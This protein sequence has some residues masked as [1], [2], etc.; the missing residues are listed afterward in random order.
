MAH[1]GQYYCS[2]PKHVTRFHY[3][4]R[5]SVDWSYL[6]QIFRQF[7]HQPTNQLSKQP[8]KQATH[9]PTNQP[10]NQA[11]HQPIFDRL[12][13]NQLSK[14]PSNPPTH[15]VTHRP[16]D[17]PSNQP[18]NGSW[19][20]AEVIGQVLQ[21]LEQSVGVSDRSGGFIVVL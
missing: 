12:P 16:A 10:T 18:N 19:R 7:D 17:Q 14:P 3:R 15:P 21:Q 1:Y 20:R 13:T 4:S 11:T 8:T 6:N 5:C 9:P 2:Q